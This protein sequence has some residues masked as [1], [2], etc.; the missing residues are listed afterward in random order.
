M[1]AGN[2]AEYLAYLEKKVADQAAA[3]VA[4]A[5]AAAA[6]KASD[7]AKAVIEAIKNNTPPALM[8]VPEIPDVKLAASSADEL[9]A[10]LE[11]YTMSAAPE[12]SP[13]GGVARWRRTEIRP[14]S[15]PISRMRCQQAS[16]SFMTKPVLKPRQL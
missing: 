1:L 11:G 14:S 13:A 8:G 7:M 12:E 3:A 9:T 5:E 15:T 16:R 4:T 2:E 6:E 10:T